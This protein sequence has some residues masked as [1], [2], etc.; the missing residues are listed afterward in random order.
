MK[1]LT[2][3]VSPKASDA[4]DERLSRLRV[5]IDAFNKAF[6]QISKESP[7]SSA[8]SWRSLSQTVLRLKSQH[9]LKYENGVYNKSKR[10]FHSI[11]G[12]INDH[13]NVFK[14]LPQGEKYV[15]PICGS[16]ELI[17]KVS[18]AQEAGAVLISSRRLPSTMSTSARSLVRHSRKLMTSSA[19]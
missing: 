19:L 1:W 4:L 17:V 7:E 13:M 16:L 9:D 11:C 18:R 8:F 5:T 15:A 14:I 3:Y 12:K 10:G 2:L 6:P